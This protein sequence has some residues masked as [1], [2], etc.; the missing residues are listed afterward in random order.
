MSTHD[1]DCVIF[2]KKGLFD[3]GFTSYGERRR[4][5]RYTFLLFQKIGNFGL[6]KAQSQLTFL[7]ELEAYVHVDLGL[8]GSVFE[9]FVIFFFFSITQRI[10]SV[11][12]HG[13]QKVQRWRDVQNFSG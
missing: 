13:L 5:A 2:F 3:G 4:R 6:F 8:K 1:F 7:M 9:F 10:L 12:L 11:L